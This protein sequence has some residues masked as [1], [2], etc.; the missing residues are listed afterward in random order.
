MDNTNTPKP[1][2]QND[3]QSY[4]TKVSAKEI[5]S[6]LQDNAGSIDNSVKDVVQKNYSFLEK[7][8]TKRGL[9]KLVEKIRTKQ[10]KNVAQFY[11]LIYKIECDGKLQAAAEFVN[12]RTKGLI[13]EFQDQ[14]RKQTEAKLVEINRDINSTREKCSAEIRRGFEIVEKDKDIP[15]LY[16]GNIV[17]MHNEMEMNFDVVNS[18]MEKFKTGVTEEAKRYELKI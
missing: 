5:T 18:H 13:L 16:D 4:E 6:F 3:L 1:N 14:F 7:Y 2:Y 8:V 9:V 12:L 10:I 15:D 17:S 11:E